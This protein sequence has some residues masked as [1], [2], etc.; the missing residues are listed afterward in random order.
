MI[1]PEEATAKSTASI[2]P[3]QGNNSPVSEK[4]G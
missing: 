1:A 2:S 3:A 4:S